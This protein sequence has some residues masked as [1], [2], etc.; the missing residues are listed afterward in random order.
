MKRR[1]QLCWM[2]SKKH[3]D[4]D[5]DTL[6]LD[7][8]IV[9]GS[10]TVP[11]YYHPTAF[12]YAVVH[13]L[14]VDFVRSFLARARNCLFER[15]LWAAMGSANRQQHRQRTRIRY[16]RFVGDF[17]TGDAGNRANCNVGLFTPE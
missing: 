10:S 17:P 16:V 2:R 13:G 12:Y 1:V 11:T 8:K 3:I 9:D 15:G 14:C 6:A 4:S 5:M 7:E